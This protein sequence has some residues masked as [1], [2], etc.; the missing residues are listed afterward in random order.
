MALNVKKSQVLCLKKAMNPFPNI[1]GQGTL[2][3]KDDC[4]KTPIAMFRH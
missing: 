2:F 4:W 3:D 1:K